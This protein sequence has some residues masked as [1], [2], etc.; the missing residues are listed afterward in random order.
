MVKINLKIV[1]EMELLTEVEL[2]GNDKF[3]S[4]EAQGFITCR[5]N[6]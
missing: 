6:G 2:I 1:K 4:W 3:G 5:K